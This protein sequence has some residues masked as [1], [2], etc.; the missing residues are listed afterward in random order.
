MGEIYLPVVCGKMSADFVGRERR[1]ANV[2]I[3][4]YPLTNGTS[5]GQIT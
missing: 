5:L 2:R 1:G 3:R 4:I